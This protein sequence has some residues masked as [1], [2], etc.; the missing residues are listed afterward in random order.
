MKHKDK[1]KLLSE[2]NL[3][4]SVPNTKVGRMISALID[5]YISKHPNEFKQC[6]I[7]D[8]KYPQNKHN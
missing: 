3:C 8:A 5:D 7:F 1:E 2:N 4:I 6:I